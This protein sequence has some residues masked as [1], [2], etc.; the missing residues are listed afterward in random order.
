M[1]S[2]MVTDLAN[3]LLL[4]DQWNP[5]DLH[6]LDQSKTPKPK[7][8]LSLTQ[9]GSALPM[10]VKIPL[11]S[12]LRVDGFIDN[13][14]SVFL[15]TEQNRERVPHTVPLAMFVMNCPHVGDRTE[16]IKRC[17]I[18]S[19]PK[20]FMEGTPDECQVVLGWLLDT[21]RLHA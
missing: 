13:L 5:V 1:F 7:I 3:E 19:L 20:L 9:L 14:I 12:T 17:N 4:Y 6:N 15:D 16:P 10:A 11:S 21:N 18:L 2:E 8:W